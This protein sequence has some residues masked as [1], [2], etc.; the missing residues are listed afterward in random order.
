[1]KSYRLRDFS[2]GL[3]NLAA[4]HAILDSEAVIALNVVVGDGYVESRNG[5]TLWNED[6]SRSGGITMM[7]P[8]Y[9]RDG[10]TKELFFANDDDYFTLSTTTTTGTSWTTISDYGTAVKNPFAYQYQNQLALGTGIDANESSR[11]DGDGAITTL[12]TPADSSDLRFYEYHQGQNV[13][14]LL[15][16]GNVRD[17][18]SHNNSIL[19]YT[20]DVDDWSGGGTLGI[21]T[22]DGQSL[23]AIKSHSNIL[24]YKDNSM[25]RLDIVY[26]SNAGTHVMRVLERFQDI[27]AINHEV[28]QI[29]VNDCLSLSQRHGVRGSQQVQTQLGGSESRR[30]ST[31]IKP[32]LDTIDWNTAKT[33]ARAIVWDEK[34]FI[35]VPMGG[36]AT[37][38]AVF[39]GHLDSV[40]P[41]GEI[42]WTLFSI[43]AGSFAIFQDTNGIER[44]MVGDSNNP[45]ISFW[46]KDSYSDNQSDIVTQFRMKRQDMGDLEV[47]K[48]QDI[49]LSGLMTELTE[50]FVTIYVDGVSTVYK[51]DKEQLLNPSAYIWSHVIGS[52]IIGGNTTDSTKPRWL[53]VLS[54]PDS[55]RVGSEIQIEISSRG[56]GYYWRLDYLSINEDIN[57]NLYADNHFVSADN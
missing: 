8:M 45:R 2:G 25:Y 19:Y 36:S 9:M 7:C 3:N 54:L 48:F 29:S 6:T 43:N 5:I 51:I 57:T 50:I 1:M 11:W 56:K 15:G 38:N 32:L 46:D 14:Y 24:A 49:I 22:N 33:T 40:T 31:K 21:G 27:G 53:A 16:A 10:S 41:T 13:A 35:S 34:Y 47:D 12:T 4:E 44:L 39:V 28:C 42:P 26:E 52:E 55:L 23:T 30:L 18:A 20:L 17:N 37:N